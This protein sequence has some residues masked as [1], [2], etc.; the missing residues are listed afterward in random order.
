MNT[1]LPLRRQTS[2]AA[3]FALAALAALGAGT[4]LGCVAAPADSDLGSSSAACSTPPVGAPGAAEYSYF[5]AYRTWRGV[6]IAQPNGVRTQ[7]ADG[8]F[9]DSC[10][11]TL[12]LGH[13]LLSSA[14]CD[15]VLAELGDDPRVATLLFVGKTELGRDGYGRPAEKLSV[16]EVWRAPEPRFLTGNVYHVSHE[17]KRALLVGT[18]NESDVRALDFGHSPTMEDCDPDPVSGQTVCTQSHAGVLEDAEAPAGLVVYGERTGNG[19]VRI[20]QY[21]IKIDVGQVHLPNG[22]WYCRADQT[23]CPNNADCWDDAHQCTV[24]HGHGRG[25]IYGRTGE[26]AI[27]PWLLG[28]TQLLAGDPTRPY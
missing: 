4:S 22:Y 24:E 9:A 8:R 21:F 11:A 5:V 7:C 12:D 16:S 2:L 20:R 28:T 25:Q 10:E 14:D 23:A 26:P 6:R 13:T 27:Q 17:A 1:C 18:W 15:K 3:L 19:V